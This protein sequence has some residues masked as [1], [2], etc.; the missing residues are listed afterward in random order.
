MRV[1][2]DGD[3]VRRSA[4]ITPP[5]TGFLFIPAYTGPIQPEI[6]RCNSAIYCLSFSDVK[7]L[8]KW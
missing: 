5:K 7:M 1:V 2:P 8:K 3:P 4:K 6:A